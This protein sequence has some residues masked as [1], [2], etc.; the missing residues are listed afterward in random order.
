[1]KK[2]GIMVLL[3][4]LLCFL[5]LTGCGPEKGVKIEQQ[6]KPK[7]TIKF[8]GF[9]AGLLQYDGIDHLLK[10]YQ[11]QHPDTVVA[12][13]G[14]KKDYTNVLFSRLDSGSADDLFMLFPYK[15]TEAQKKGY[16]GNQIYDLTG[17]P[18]VANYNETIQTMINV[19]GRIPG[20]PL[21]MAGI[22]M[23]V[24]TDMLAKYNLKVPKSHTEFMHCCE[25]LKKN[26]ITPLTVGLSPQS[27]VLGNALAFSRAMYKDNKPFTNFAALNDGSLKVGDMLRPGLEY[28][29]ELKDKGYWLVDDAT[30]HGTFADETGV[31]GNQRAAFMVTGTWFLSL[32][33]RD[34]K[35]FKYEFIPLP[36][37]DEPVLII[38]AACP[39]CINAHGK[40][41]ERAMEFLKF[42]SQPENV[43]AFTASQTSLSP[44]KD[45]K[46]DNPVLK[47]VAATAA[48]GRLISD[49]DPRFK[50]D[51]STVLIKA[52]QEIV[53]E[54]KAVDAVVTEINNL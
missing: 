20:V 23:V 47:N 51:L 2:S 42:I 33:E 29:K 35:G 38:R 37:A 19:G 52:T 45:G 30:T 16:I 10:K 7:I 8:L 43:R 32:I 40:Q 1:M 22:G 39:V 26:G 21:E 41:R 3:A 25:V 27:T 28:V 14:I 53:L 50:I 4:S 49:G 24:N 36:V 54:N 6:E 9:K 44:L 48:A 5:M 17:Q 46:N 18:F 13:E 31:F 12:Y 15:F 34:V 11:E